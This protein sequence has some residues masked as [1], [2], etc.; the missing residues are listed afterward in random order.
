MF[1]NAK[2]YYLGVCL[3]M[4]F[5]IFEFRCKVTKKK[6]VKKKKIKKKMVLSSHRQGNVTSVEGKSPVNKKD[7][8][9]TKIQDIL[10]GRSRF[11]IRKVPVVEPTREQ[12]LNSRQQTEKVHS[13]PPVSGI[14]E[15][16][17][18]RCRLSFFVKLLI[19]VPI[20]Y[21]VHLLDLFIH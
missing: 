9:K 21:C 7:V 14:N 5:V 18:N 20:W 16:K 15:V 10:S 4:I 13:F 17:T 2:Y 19:C 8:L 12:D 3:K 11:V 1:F 6:V